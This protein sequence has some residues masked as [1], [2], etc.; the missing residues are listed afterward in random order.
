MAYGRDAAFTADALADHVGVAADV[1]ASF[2]RAFSVGFGEREDLDRWRDDPKRAV[3]GEMEVMRKSPVLHD[4]HG[5]YLTFAL[6]SLFYGL[7]DTLTDALK[8]D[9]K[10]WERFQAHRA[11]V[12]EERALNALARAF[13]AGGRTV[14]SSTS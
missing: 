4:G 12:I 1:A 3:G 10:V 14:P 9:P 5:N 13:G 7:R 8:K 11:H 2:L 6:D